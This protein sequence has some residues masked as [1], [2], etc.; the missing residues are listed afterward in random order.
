MEWLKDRILQECLQSRAKVN[1]MNSMIIAHKI[2]LKG[3]DYCKLF[4]LPFAIYS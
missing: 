3:L 2:Q 4:L 1:A